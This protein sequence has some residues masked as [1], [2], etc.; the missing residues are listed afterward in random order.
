MPLPYR[1]ESPTQYMW[2]GRA[3]CVLV[4]MVVVTRRVE[5]GSITLVW[6][7]NPETNIAGYTV[8]YGT[9]SGTYT[10]TINVGNVTSWTVNGLTDGQTYYFA[11]DAYTSDGTHSALSAQVSGITDS[12]NPAALT[13]PAPSSTLGGSSAT[14]QWS[15]GTGVSAYHLSIAT[16]PG[17]SDLYDQAMGTNLSQTVT[18]LPTNGSTLYVRIWSQD[19]RRV[20][21]QRLHVHR[22]QYT[23]SD[24]RAL[25]LPGVQL[26][27]S[28]LDFNED[29][30][31]CQHRQ[32]S[33]DGQRDHLSQ[34]IH[35]E[36]VRNDRSRRNASSH[37]DVHADGR[38]EL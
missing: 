21:L 12:S 38:D 15:A 1:D 14:F 16:A 5:A 9:M 13:A 30:D 11:V 27:A 33:D 29:T 24:H 7:P 23:H 10:S 37:G 34:R 26:H 6:D 8:Y 32:L 31:D 19:Q 18:G 20:A 35:R 28:R 22:L 36:L 4:L 3:L 17:G 2:M 25:G